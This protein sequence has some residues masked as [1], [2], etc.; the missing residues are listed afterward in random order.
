LSFAQ[1]YTSNL[2][3]NESNCHT[4]EELTHGRSKAIPADRKG[5]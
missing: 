5:L 4:A 3:M 1:K 2:A